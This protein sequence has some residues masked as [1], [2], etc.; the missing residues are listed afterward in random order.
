MD[1]GPLSWKDSRRLVEKSLQ[2]VPE[3]P[4]SLWRTVASHAEGNPFYLEELIKKLIEDG[5][6]QKKAAGWIVNPERLADLQ[7]P[8]TIT[9]ILQARMDRLSR[10]ERAVLQQAS[11]VGRVFWDAVLVYLNQM[12]N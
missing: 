1:L 8:T 4:E 6:V 7:L 2:Q 3:L 5:V 9:G 12:Q 10:V 11:V